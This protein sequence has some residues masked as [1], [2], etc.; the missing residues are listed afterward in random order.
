MSKTLKRCSRS[1]PSTAAVIDFYTTLIKQKGK[2]ALCLLKLAPN[3][4]KQLNGSSSLERILK[5]KGNAIKSN[6]VRST[7]GCLQLFSDKSE[8]TLS[9]GKS[10]LCPL[11]VTLWEILK[12]HCR[13]LTWNEISITSYLPVRFEMANYESSTNA[14]SVHKATS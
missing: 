5:H 6:P 11:Q 9:V 12:N 2:T 10:R 8:V 14:V 13:E 1:W 3:L 4:A 7:A